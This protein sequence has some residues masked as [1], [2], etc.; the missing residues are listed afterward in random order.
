M[1][2]PSNKKKWPTANR[3]FKISSKNWNFR[4]FVRLRQS[5]YKNAVNPAISL[6]SAWRTGLTKIAAC[7]CK[8]TERHDRAAALLSE[9]TEELGSPEQ[10]LPVRQFA[11]CATSN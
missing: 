6:N 11:N 10:N 3:Y 5:L 9:Q 2:R 7:K 8:D 1:P 4:D